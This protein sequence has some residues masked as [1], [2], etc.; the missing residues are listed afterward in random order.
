MHL[1]VEVV[2]RALRVERGGE[3]FRA[4]TERRYYPSQDPELGPVGRFFE[5]EATSEIALNAGM[6]RDFW[7]AYQPDQESIRR[8]VAAT[9]AAMAIPSLAV[10]GVVCHP[11][12]RFG[13]TMPQALG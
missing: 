1:E 4:V 9:L 13:G 2:R 10:A 12:P 3:T 6:W 5:G 8:V 11:H 7:A